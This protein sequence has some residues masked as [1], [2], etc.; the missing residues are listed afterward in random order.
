MTTCNIWQTKPLLPE[1]PFFEGDTIRILD[2]PDTRGNTSYAHLIGKVGVM[3][4]PAV[5]LGPRSQ[6][7]LVR[8]EFKDGT[9]EDMFHWRV[10]IIYRQK[11]WEV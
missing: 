5:G 7:R 3:I 4:N 8:V 9:R 10:E 6:A 1:S 11:T 2:H